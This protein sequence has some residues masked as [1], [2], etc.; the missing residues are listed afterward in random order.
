[1]V[2]G[3]IHIQMERRGI[4]IYRLS[5]ETGIKYELLRRIFCGERKMSADEL[6]LIL[7][8]TGIAFEEIK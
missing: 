7:D 5:K 8:K 1:M 2:E 3:K 4:T 6:L